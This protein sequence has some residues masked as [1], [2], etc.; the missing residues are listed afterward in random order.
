MTNS[1]NTK[2]NQLIIPAWSAIVVTSA[3][4]ISACSSTQKAP[5]EE[6]IATPSAQNAPNNSQTTNSQTTQEGISSSPY[7][8]TYNQEPTFIDPN[9]TLNNYPTIPFENAISAALIQ[10]ETLVDKAQYDEAQRVSIGIDRNQL[11]LQQQARL[12]LAIA[13]IF[14]SKNQTN[15]S[16][17]SLEQTQPILLSRENTAK[18]YW[19]YARIMYQTERYQES[20]ESLANR[21]NYL[22]RTQLDSNQ[23]MMTNILSSLSP[24]QLETIKNSTSNQRLLYWLDSKIPNSTNSFIPLSS[25][26]NII[27]NIAELTQIESIWQA[28][29]PKQIAVL[30]PFSSEFES[31]AKEFEKGINAAHSSN[32]SPFKPQ[33][34]FY[35]VGSGDID[36]KIQLANQNGAELVIGPLGNEASNQ[37]LNSSS[38]TPIITIGGNLANPRN[39]QNTFS[40]N[41]ESDAIVI[42]HHAR[43]KGYVKALVLAPDSARGNRLASAFEN[44]WTSLNGISERQP[45]TEN[46]FDHSG[47]I[48]LALG[49]YSSENRHQQ[50]TSTI[51]TTTQF[52]PSRKSQ[53]DMIFLASNFADAKNLKPQLNYHDAHNVPTYGPSSINMTNIPDSQK[54]DL[55]G[56]IIPEMPALI[57]LEN[58]REDANQSALLNQES[59]QDIPTHTENAPTGTINNNTKNHNNKNHNNKNIQK[60]SRLEALGYDSY[61]IAPILQQINAQSHTYSGK[62]G[63]IT[64]D[65]HGN[66]Q[67]LPTWVKFSNGKLYPVD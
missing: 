37:A 25:A 63:L 8:D 13:T 24:Q 41:P 62:T 26:N 9:N 19:L 48:K 31:V 56:L 32:T 14:S 36:Y 33:L 23:S 66:I 65:Q 27:S 20:L 51:N 2:I 28:N 39:R 43:N 50:L 11:S 38:H 5:T 42:A 10:L 22:D 18:Y 6:I 53:V 4:I 17:N 30:L 40:L 7:Q 49:I 52:I 59:S 46:E 34:R 55:D 61:Q 45:Y 64:V 35:D 67:H 21:S 15:D 3:L 54:A 44:A 60:M 1:Q 47:V 29:S 57:P 16:L 58:D 12:S